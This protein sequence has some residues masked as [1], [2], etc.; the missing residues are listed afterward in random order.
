[1][2]LYTQFKCQLLA[3]S[4]EHA[5]RWAC[6]RVELNPEKRGGVHGSFWCCQTANHEADNTL[7]H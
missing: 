7:I 5:D 1:M 3:E 4:G 2:L 6:S